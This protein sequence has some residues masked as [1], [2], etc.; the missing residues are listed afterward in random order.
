QVTV[1]V[2][3]IDNAS[4]SYPSNTICT[5]SGNAIPTTNTAGTFSSTAGLVFANTTTGEI[6]VSASTGGTYTVTYTTNGSCPNSD[7]QSINITDAPDAS[8]TYSD[9][10]FCTG[11]A[12]PMPLF[13]SGS[14]GT[15]S[16]T[17]GLVFSNVS[18]GEVNLA[19]STP[20]NYVI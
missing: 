9:V 15:F 3:P 19:T 12:N 1:N 11:T 20:G 13:G 6:N 8:F 5:T 4:F 17:T 18:T 14:A 16:S 7:V 2:T 10:N